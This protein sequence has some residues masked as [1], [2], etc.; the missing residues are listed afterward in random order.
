MIS[1]FF[2]LSNKLQIYEFI[3]VSTYPLVFEAGGLMFLIH[4]AVGILLK[5]Y[6]DLFMRRDMLNKAFKIDANEKDKL[7]SNSHSL[8]K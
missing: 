1:I 3:T 6:S 4:L 2:T 7:V 5:P 8:V